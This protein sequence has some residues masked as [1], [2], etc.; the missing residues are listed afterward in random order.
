[1]ENNISMQQITERRMYQTE[2]EDGCLGAN[3]GSL[4]CRA[5]PISNT[6]R[7]N[8]IRSKMKVEEY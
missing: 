5:S 2:D 8:Y 1:M 3:G 6:Q 4:E 7:G